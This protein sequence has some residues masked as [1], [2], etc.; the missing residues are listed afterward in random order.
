[1]AW[2]GGNIECHDMVGLRYGIVRLWYGM[3]W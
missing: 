2:H 1:M 3:A